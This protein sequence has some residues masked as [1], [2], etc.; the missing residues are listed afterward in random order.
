MKLCT[1]RLGGQHVRRTACFRYPKQRFHGDGNDGQTCA[2]STGP[3]DGPSKGRKAPAPVLAS[4]QAPPSGEEDAGPRGIGRSM[5]AEGKRLARARGLFCLT[6]SRT[7][8]KSER[9]DFSLSIF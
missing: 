6:K 9:T 4:A 5:A 7:S 8:E 3:R 1:G 2:E